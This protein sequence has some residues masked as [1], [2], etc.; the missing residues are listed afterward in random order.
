[1]F[2][3]MFPGVAKLGNMCFGRKICVREAKMF[4]TPGKNI[5]CFRAAKFVSATHVSRAAKLGNIC[6]RN[7]VSATMFPSLARS[8]ISRGWHEIVSECVPH[9]QH[10]YIMFSHSNNQILHLWR[11]CYHSH[12]RGKKLACCT[13]GTHFKTIPYC[14]LQN[15]SV[16]LPHWQF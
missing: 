12:R 2:L 4:L 10:T 1:M 6:I 13:C 11:S 5:F 8:L 3:V 16:K 14:P 15:N 9:V 7:N